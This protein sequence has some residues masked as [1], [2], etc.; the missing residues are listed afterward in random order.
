MGIKKVIAAINKKQSIFKT[1][2][3]LIIVFI[4]VRVDASNEMFIGTNYPGSDGN[5]GNGDQVFITESNRRNNCNQILDHYG[6]DINIRSS[7]GWKRVV[8]NKNTHLY[9]TKNSNHRKYLY[10]LE[11]CLLYSNQIRIG[12]NRGDQ[13]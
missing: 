12:Q 11:Q 7:A 5:G 9:I 8:K 4:F 3:I 2:F 6:I 1:L 10:E 13:Q